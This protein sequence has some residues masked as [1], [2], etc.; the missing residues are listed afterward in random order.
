MT[1]HTY[2]QLCENISINGLEIKLATPPL[3]VK[4]GM[5]KVAVSQENSGVQMAENAVMLL[6]KIR[7]WHV[8]FL[9]IL[10]LLR[11]PHSHRL[12]GLPHPTVSICSH[13]SSL[14]EQISYTDW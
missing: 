8:V 1:G 2:R 10:E 14:I 5:S 13:L 12:A 11:K 3:L 4:A 6:W 9:Q 7:F